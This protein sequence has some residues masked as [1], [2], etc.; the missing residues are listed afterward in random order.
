MNRIH[1]WKVSV[2]LCA[3]V[4]KKQ[5]KLG[6]EQRLLLAWRPFSI[7]CRS[8]VIKSIKLLLLM[9][10]VVVVVVCACVRKS[11]LL[12]VS[13]HTTWTEISIHHSKWFTI[14]QMNDMATNTK[15]EM[16]TEHSAWN[17]VWRFKNNPFVPFPAIE[18]NRN[19]SICWKT[20][21][22]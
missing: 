4:K 19:S 11:V 10:V 14:L 8:F 20:L 1:Q 13:A 18:N 3:V 2:V 15:D 6:S 22:F 12:D 5:Q 21:A 17:F 16:K 9:V 7:Q